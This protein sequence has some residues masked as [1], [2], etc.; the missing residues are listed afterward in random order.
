MMVRRGLGRRVPHHF[1]GNQPIG[2]AGGQEYI[3]EP[4]VRIPHREAQTG[5]VRMQSTEPVDV[6]RVQ[7]D[8]DRAPA[9]AAP[10][11]PHQRPKAV[12]EFS[13]IEQ[14]AGRQCVEVSGQNMESAVVRSDRAEK[15]SQLDHA[16]TFRPRRMNRTE[17]HAE[18]REI[19]ACWMNLEKGVT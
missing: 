8:F 18:H 9:H 15:I 4:H 1:T 11:Q 7:H 6:S 12:R 5:I 2:M 19:N 13:E 10:A 3:V 17:V 16:V 14:L